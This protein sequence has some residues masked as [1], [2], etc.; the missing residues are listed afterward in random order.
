MKV[1]LFVLYIF[2]ADG[3]LT[4]VDNIQG[5]AACQTAQSVVVNTTEVAIPAT[6]PKLIVAAH[7][8]AKSG[9][10]TQVE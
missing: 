4:T 6:A 2:H 8:V 10:G 5:F 3:S 9:P 7:C 1:L